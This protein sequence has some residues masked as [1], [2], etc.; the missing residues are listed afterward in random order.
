MKTLVIDVNKCVGCRLC[1]LVCSYS[2]YRIFSPN[3]SGIQILKNEEKSINIPLICQHCAK[4]VCMEVCPQH[5][6]YRNEKTG[7]ILINDKLCIKCGEC[8]NACPFKA[9]HQDPKNKK[10]IKC[11]LCDG[12]IECYKYCP[13]KAIKILPSDKKSLKFKEKTQKSIFK[14]L[15]QLQI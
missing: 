5:A 12:E 7:A 10:I 2:H 9:L 4:P 3:K 1:E 6:I 15:K 14:A 13:T 8:I 11:D